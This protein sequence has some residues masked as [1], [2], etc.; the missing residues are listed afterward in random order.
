MA[1]IGFPAQ[2]I[3][4]MTRTSWSRMERGR[5]VGLLPSHECTPKAIFKEFKVDGLDIDMEWKYPNGKVVRR[6]DSRNLPKKD[7]SKTDRGSTT[8]VPILLTDNGADTLMCWQP[9]KVG[10]CGTREIRGWTEVS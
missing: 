9:A 7:L 1:T 5:A 2:R 10:H 3:K 4:A 6:R 8:G